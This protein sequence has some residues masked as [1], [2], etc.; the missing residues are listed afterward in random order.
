MS[1]TTKEIKETKKPRSQSD[2]ALFGV[3]FQYVQKLSVF[4]GFGARHWFQSRVMR[5]I[6]AARF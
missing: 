2:I 3:S 1:D 6:R 4:T 5:E